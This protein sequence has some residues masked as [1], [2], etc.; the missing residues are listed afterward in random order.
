M[1]DYK[2]ADTQVRDGWVKIFAPVP[3]ARLRLFCFS[4]AGG[5]A[6]NFYSWP[7]QL[8][9]SIELCAVQ[10]PG[11][12]GRMGEPSFTSLPVLVDALLPALLPYF[13][14]PFS[15]FGHSMGAM[16]GFEL[17]RQLRRETGRE[18]LQLFV[19][20][21]H[22][23]QIPHNSPI[24]Y[25]LPEPEFLQELRRL[26]GTP[27]EVLEHPELMS[28]LLSL[29]RADFELVQSYIYQPGEPL[30]CPIAV[31]GGTEDVDVPQSD[32]APWREQ[33]IASFSL[34]LFPGDHFFLHSSQALL[35]QHLSE[36]LQYLV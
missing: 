23:P 22:A 35:L 12:G 15:F 10:L 28:L 1:S 13:D 2:K 8:S 3:R 11:R 21:Q 18:P 16:I 14:K 25:N 26:N 5:S 30:N 20:G 19:S 27:R 34:Q 29:L 17:A 9:A 4:Y 36:H 6:Q 24:T 32:L 33:T 7:R 31:F